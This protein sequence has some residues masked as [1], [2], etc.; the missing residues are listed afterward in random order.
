[1]NKKTSLILKIAIPVVLVIIVTGIWI[2][3][4]GGLFESPKPA[5]SASVTQTPSHGESGVTG[6]AATAKATSSD[7]E[8]AENTDFDLESDHVDLEKLSSYGLPMVIDFGAAWCGPCQRMHPT[9]EK[10]NGQL[11]GKVI[12]KYIDLS[13][14]TSAGDDFPVSVFPTQFFFDKNGDPF[15]PKDPDAMGL[16]LYNLK[17]TNEHVYTAHEG[18]LTED[19]LSAIIAE[20]QK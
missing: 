4:N 18:L 9:L 16:I 13:K 17:T 20:M 1:M 3:K 6:E 10:L 8:P 14:Y 15:N 11:R 7:G 19:E 2:A 12:I 5:P